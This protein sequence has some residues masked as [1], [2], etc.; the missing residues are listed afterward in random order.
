MNIFISAGESSGDMHAAR[1]MQELKAVFR[2]EIHF[3][4]IGGINMQKE[5]LTSLVDL[6]NISVVGFLEVAKKAGLFLNLFKL[7]KQVICNNKIDLFIPVDYPGFNLKLAKYCKSQ[8]IPVFYYIVPQLWAWGKHRAEKLQ[9]NVDH[10]MVVFPFEVDYFKKYNL[11]A[12]FV[13]HP[14]LESP[15]FSPNVKDYNDRNNTLA[16]FPG[17]RKQEIKKHIPL[18]IKTAKLIKNQCKSINISIA[19]APLINENDI[20]SLIDND[21]DYSFVTDSHTLMKDSLVG[22]VKTGTSTLEAALAGMP[23]S[24]YYIASF[25]TYFLGKRLIN[26]PYISLPN[27]LMNDF[28]IQEFI[29]Q[30]ARPEYIAVEILKLIKHREYYQ[31]M[32]GIFKQITDMLGKE[33]ASHNAAKFIYDTI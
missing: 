15:A 22:I 31:E 7:C 2:E 21:I 3:F 14:L 13:G 11:D 33:K 10:L 1:L 5:G 28:V 17:S 12:H 30:D 24:M 32:Q 6:R 23:H 25:T 26:L 29:Q 8:K 27:I 16:L 19:K 4:G 18:L 20:S 9:G